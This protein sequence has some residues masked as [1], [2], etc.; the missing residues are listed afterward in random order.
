MGNHQE[1][2]IGFHLEQERFVTRRMV[3]KIGSSTITG[4]TENLDVN[5]MENI[6]RQVSL[7]FNQGIEVMIVTSGA[8]ISGKR[9]LGRVDTVLDKQV[10]ALYGQPELISEW[11]KTLNNNGVK[12]VGQLLVTDIDLRNVKTI[13]SKSLH[14]GVVVVNANDPVN[15]Y[16]MKQ[17]LV[18]ADNDR[19][20][21]FIAKEIDADTLLL[22]TDV[23]GVL[24][25]SGKVINNFS[26]KEEI[27]IF[28]AS[29]LGT[30][31][32]SSKIQVAQEFIGRA[33]IANGRSE[34]VL[35]K[36]ARGEEVGTQFH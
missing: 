14:F 30:G 35:L 17:F 6:A 5:F 11:R 36:V 20:A 23:D 4:N 13:L 15:N 24:D 10:A 34:N 7:L 26:T 29:S 21:G 2:E 31:G 3:V 16:E 22:L 33:I 8:V 12:K 18:S 28:S 25:K 9:G 27:V 1:R 32:M 19:L